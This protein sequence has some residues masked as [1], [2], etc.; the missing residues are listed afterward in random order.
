MAIASGERQCNLNAMHVC[1]FER[2]ELRESGAGLSSVG[3]RTRARG[4]L[5]QTSGARVRARIE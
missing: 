5:N 3:A 1:I 4:E 2:C